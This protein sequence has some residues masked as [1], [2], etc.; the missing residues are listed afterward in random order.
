MNKQIAELFQGKEVVIFPGDTE[1][2]QGIVH[3]VSDSG[4]VFEITRYRGR[5]DTWVEG[6]LHFVSFGNLTFREV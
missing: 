6:K 4:V 1:R 5:N 2:K 3:T